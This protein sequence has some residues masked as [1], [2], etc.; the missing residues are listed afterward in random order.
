MPTLKV[1]FLTPN[2]RAAI[3]RGLKRSGT[4]G[5]HRKSQQEHASFDCESKRHRELWD[6]RGWIVGTFTVAGNKEAFQLCRSLYGR[7]DQYDLLDAKTG[8]TTFTG[9]PHR[10]IDE[11]I[12][13]EASASVRR[14]P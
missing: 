6:A 10:C 2:G 11:L 9:S 14:F 4:A 12:H 7:I 1:R 3:I 8:R 13:R 5:E